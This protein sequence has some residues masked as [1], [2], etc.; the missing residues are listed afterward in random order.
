M[1]ALLQKFTDLKVQRDGAE[2]LFEAQDAKVGELT[3]KLRKERDALE[4]PL[5]RMQQQLNT[6]NLKQASVASE[7]ESTE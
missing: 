1:P 3:V 2:N 6:L 7:I 4:Q 5:Q